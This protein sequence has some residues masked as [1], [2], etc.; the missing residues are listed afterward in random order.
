M[1]QVVKVM[2]NQFDFLV[3]MIRPAEKVSISDAY[4]FYEWDLKTVRKGLYRYRKEGLAGLVDRSSHPHNSPN[5]TSKKDIKRII[6]IKERLRSFGVERLQYEF[7]IKQCAKKIQKYVRAAGLESK[8]WGK[9]GKPRDLRAWKEAN[10]QHLRDFDVDTKDCSD[11][12]Y[13]IERI[14]NSGPPVI[15]I[16]SEMLGPMYF[17]VP[18]HMNKPIGTVH[19]LQ[20]N[21]LIIFL[22]WVFH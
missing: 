12:P 5:K 14:R 11:I 3:N 18:I 2:D 9:R 13:Y 16:K 17:I 21:Y 8:R 19:F 6:R 7:G 20:V 1:Q 22:I 4:H 15:Y 10:H